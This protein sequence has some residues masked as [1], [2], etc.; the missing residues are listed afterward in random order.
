MDIL[1]GALVG[2]ILVLLMGVIKPQE[3]YHS[4]D[5]SVIFLIAAFVPVGT[6]MINTGTADFLASLII[7]FS[8]WVSGDLEAYLTLAFFYLLTSILT[9]A[10][11]NNAAAI[12]L[13]P[14]AISL[15]HSEG[16]EPH[17]FMVAICFAASAA[18]MT[19]L[20][21][22]TNLMV[23]SPG[24]YRFMDFVRYGAPL[25][26]LLWILASLLIPLFWPF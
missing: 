8:R 18:F 16:I 14:V 17:A 19:P 20:G 6:A 22:Q 5:W 10:V 15:A 13:T 23:Y 21:Y 26:I 24:G 12:I 9:Q 7:Y 25:N 11:S 2:A 1:T 4:V 3:A